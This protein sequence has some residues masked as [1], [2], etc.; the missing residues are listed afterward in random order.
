MEVIVERKTMF[1]T[2]Q[3]LDSSPVN[4]LWGFVDTCELGSWTVLASSNIWLQLTKL[5]FPIFSQP[6]DLEGSLKIA[7]K[8]HWKGSHHEL[9]TTDIAAKLEHTDTHLTVQEDSTWHLVLCKC[10]RWRPLTQGREVADIYV[11]RLLQFK[12]PDQHLLL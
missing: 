4:Y 12:M 5:M 7:L 1:P 3:I 11:G 8:P 10:W 6:P 9:L 2:M